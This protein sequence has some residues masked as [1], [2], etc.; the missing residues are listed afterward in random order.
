MAEQM[1]RQ[2]MMTLQ[3]VSL[4]QKAYSDVLTSLSLSTIYSLL[5]AHC[6]CDRVRLFP[7]VQSH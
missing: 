7:Y 4:K 5:L 3:E 2:Q 1:V 6:E